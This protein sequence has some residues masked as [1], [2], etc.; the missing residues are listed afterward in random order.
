MTEKQR[1]ARLR[2]ELERLQ[3]ERARQDQE[4]ALFT[5]E[6]DLDPEALAKAER[7]MRKQATASDEASPE[8]LIP[9]HALRA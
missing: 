7:E 8:P 4:L 3:A 6:L 2:F 5:D 9:T 1:T